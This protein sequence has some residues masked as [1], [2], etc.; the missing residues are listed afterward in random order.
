MKK[1]NEKKE[2]IDL[3][4]DCERE[5]DERHERIRSEYRDLRAMFPEASFNRICIRVATTIGC[6]AQT[7]KNVV[8]A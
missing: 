8:Q 7:V 2:T 6:S 1:E 5:R 3:R 4:T